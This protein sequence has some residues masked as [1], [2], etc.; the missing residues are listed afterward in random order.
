[1]TNIVDKLNAKVSK[2]ETILKKTKV[3]HFSHNISKTNYGTSHY[4][5]FGD[6]INGTGLVVRVS[7][8]SVGNNRIKGNEYFYFGSDFQDIELLK[9]FK[10]KNY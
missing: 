3:K 4:F 6:Y 9:Y 8:H 10:S 7:D 2:F 1:M 5:K